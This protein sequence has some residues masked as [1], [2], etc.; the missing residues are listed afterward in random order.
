MLFFLSEYRSFFICIFFLPPSPNL[1]RPW[2]IFFH[3][4]KSLFLPLFTLFSRREAIQI[5]Q[6]YFFFKNKRAKQRNWVRMHK[7]NFKFLQTSFAYDSGE[8]NIHLFQFIRNIVWKKTPS[9]DPREGKINRQ[10]KFSLSS[11]NAEWRHDFLRN[12]L[13]RNPHKWV[14]F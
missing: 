7:F 14:A 1:Q 12:R 13:F 9:L 6:L 5:N 11:N 8:W 4:I 2:S 3:F 10:M